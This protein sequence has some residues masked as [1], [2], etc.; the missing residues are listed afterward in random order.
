MLG[1]EPE[2]RNA[3]SADI[4]QKEQCTPNDEPNSNSKAA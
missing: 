4:Q 1:H 3:S 2:N